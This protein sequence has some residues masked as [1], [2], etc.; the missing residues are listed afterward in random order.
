MIGAAAVLAGCAITREMT[1][2]VATGDAK[3]LRERPDDA[4][5][6]STLARPGVFIVAFDGVDRRLLYEMLRQGDLP[7][8]AR[9]LG[10]KDFRHAYFDETMLSTLPS[11][12][13]A[14]WVTTFTGKPPAHHGVTGN[15]FFIRSKNEFAAPVPVTFSDPAVVLSSFTDG[16]ANGLVLVPSVFER[17]RQRDPHALAWVAMHH[18]HAGADKLLLTDRGVLLS[19]MK[20]YF[21]DVVKESFTD[22]TAMATYAELDEQVFEEL[23]ELLD[24]HDEPIADVVDLYVAG[25]D[26]YA[27]VATEGPDAARR[28]YLEQVIEPQIEKLYGALDARGALRDRYFMVISDHGHTEVRHDEKHALGMNR[29]GKDPPALLAKAGFRVRSFEKEVSPDDADYDTV[30]AYQG[31]MAYVY[32]ADRTTCPARKDGKSTGSCNWSRPPRYEQDVLEVAGAFF[33]NDR[34]GKL[35]PEMKG[36]LD[37]VL[38]RE[39]KAPEEVDEPFRVYV[40][41]GRTQAL[42][43][44]LAEHPHP[45]YVALETRLRDL[46]VGPVGEHAGDVLLIARNGTEQDADGR[47]YFSGEYHSWHGSPSRRDSEVPLIVAHHEKSREQLSAVVSSVLGD[48]PRQQKVAELILRLRFGTGQGSDE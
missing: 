30:L 23:F 6:K 46:A 27:H 33:D 8:L 35:V 29:D 13:M 21:Q 9:L 42:S 37:M 12:T 19:A 39:P 32:V 38:V 44:Y 26:L 16:Y 2:L 48:T 45:H 25:T 24:D 31:A 10:G 3:D 11:T 20:A 34:S 18:Y 36:T 14:A 1:E 4:P 22:E 17:M 7:A 15:E 41:E 5:E 40:G 43:D 47:Y 28:K